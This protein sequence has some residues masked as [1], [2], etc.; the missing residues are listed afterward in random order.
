MLA[1][2]NSIYQQSNKIKIAEHLAKVYGLA[3]MDAQKSHF[4]RVVV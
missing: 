3:A 4:L 1:H 2:K